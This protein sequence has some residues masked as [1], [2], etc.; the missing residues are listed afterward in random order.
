MP[1]PA[2]HPQRISALDAAALLAIESASALHT[3]QRE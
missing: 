3:A 1:K 2:A